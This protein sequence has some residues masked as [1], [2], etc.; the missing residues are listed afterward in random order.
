MSITTSRASHATEPEGA[1]PPKMISVREAA[2]ILR[3]SEISVRRFL[4]QRK[5]RRYKCGG[6][7]LLKESEV[8]GL[9]Q[10]QN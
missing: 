10:E 7:T 9:I 1:A 4:T 2:N 6:R 5:L 3:L 8:V